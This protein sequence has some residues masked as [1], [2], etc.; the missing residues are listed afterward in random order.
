MQRPYA[1]ADGKPPRSACLHK[2]SETEQMCGFNYMRPRRLG[3]FEPGVRPWVKPTTTDGRTRRSTVVG[4]AAMPFGRDCPD[5]FEGLEGPGGWALGASGISQIDLD[6]ATSVVELC[7]SSQGVVCLTMD[8]CEGGDVSGD[9]NKAGLHPIQDQIATAKT[10]KAMTDILA[11]VCHGLAQIRRPHPHLED[12]GLP[13]DGLWDHDAAYKRRFCFDHGEIEY[14]L[15]N[16]DR[17]M[18]PGNFDVPNAAAA[19][20]AMVQQHGNS[21]SKFDPH[22]RRCQAECRGSLY[23]HVYSVLDKRESGTEALYLER[24]KTCLTP[25]S[26]LVERIGLRHRWKRIKMVFVDGA[27]GC[28]ALLKTE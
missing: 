24:W 14:L 27:N 6:T 16:A 4:K 13:P 9:I 2:R 11:L 5:T 21:S 10:R 28:G 7:D 8:L 15:G 1:G 25:E 26:H 17:W 20:E 23:F 19:L 3:D 22:S 12:V 18:F